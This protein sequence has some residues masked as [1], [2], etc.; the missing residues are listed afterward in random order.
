MSSILYFCID[1]HLGIPQGLKV[2]FGNDTFE[3]TLVQDS[4]VG[5]RPAL[6]QPRT[7]DQYR[8]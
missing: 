1:P 7:R 6:A 3:R 5:Q 4:T 2:L 8:H